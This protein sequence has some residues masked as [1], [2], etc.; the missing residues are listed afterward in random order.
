MENRELLRKL[1][2]EGLEE[3]GLHQNQEYVD[4]LAFELD[5]VESMGFVPYFLVMWDIA[6]FARDNGILYGPGRGSGCGSLL[7]Y[8]L[9]I[10][11]VDPIKYGLYFERFLNP[12]RVSPPDIDW[13]CAERD[14][15]IE[16]LEDRY[17]KDKVARV[18]SLNFLRTKSA[19]RDIGRVLGEDYKLIEELADLVPPPVAGLWNSFEA[20]C[21]V[22]PRL[23]N[24]KYEHIINPVRKL[25]GVVRS[26][27]THAGGVA[28]A[29]GPINQFVP[30]YKDKDGNAISQ[31]DWRD[32][33]AA[34]L[35]KF[36]IL[37]LS[38]L[39]VI[40]LCLQYIREGGKDINLETLEDGDAKAYEV[41]QS[42]NL[43]GIFQLGGSE[44]IK[45]LTVQIAPKNIEDLSMVTSLFRP[46]PLCISG[47][48]KILTGIQRTN[49]EKTKAVGY[50]TKTIKE[51]YNDYE[52]KT[53]REWRQHPRWVISVGGSVFKPTLT[54]S[55]I[56]AVHKSEPKQMYRLRT[57]SC[58][59]GPNSGPKIQALRAS[60]DH[61]VLTLRRGWVRVESLREGDYICVFCEWKN[62]SLDVNH[63]SGN[64][65]TDNSPENLSFL[66]PNHHR[67]YT[68]GSITQEELKE[69]KKKY[70]LP[71]PG[72]T[73]WIRL[74]DVI[75][76]G[77]DQSY[78]LELEGG[79]HNF[80]ADDIV[81]HNSSGM[82]DDAVAVRQ[83]KK[84]E[85]YIHPI[86]EPILRPTHCIPVFQ[87]QIMRICTDLCGYTLPE[88]DKM[89]KILG[90]KLQK[91]MK[92][93]KPKFVGGAV[94]SGVPEQDAAKLFHQLEDYAQYLFNKA[95]AVAYS[96]ITY[97]TAYLKAHYPVE[98]YAAL[99]ACE[100]KPDMVMQYVS[101]AR[102]QYI[103]ILPPD[104]NLSGV[105]H[106][107]EEG[108][109]RYGLGHIKG[110]R[111]SVAEEIVR[112]RNAEANSKKVE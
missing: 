25:W 49:T 26:Y 69:A 81:V 34:G 51:L 58:T 23:L 5:A 57:T 53:E 11:L 54:K 112:L 60:K 28:I 17:G 36:D 1:A 71:Q 64:R 74:V 40:Q 91:E 65:Y 72:R 35:L 68:E 97:W 30:L 107:P 16:Y 10:T 67:E 101:S 43:D 38:T 61:G 88:S 27:G 9:K 92:E 96:V 12:S 13:D 76:D 93:Q 37:G 20:E 55:K 82:V 29:P 47:K 89:R 2:M 73:R 110:M 18:G 33:E 31:F 78:D 99:L 86:V 6:K 52:S 106:R 84:E 46:G 4:R 42:G 59:D 14:R 94:A 63:D 108:A 104:V 15:I 50:T 56:K 90:K 41:I 21:E 22:E 24:K 79:L 87:E 32:L 109:I 70:T 83:G 103:E 19:I 39:E 44:S 105:L 48:S 80:I 111:R 77:V 102:E 66:C 95:H 8:C 62:G 3:R 45:Q 7:N 98:F 75:P 85:F 100:T